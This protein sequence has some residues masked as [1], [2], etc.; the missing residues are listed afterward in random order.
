MKP[1]RM[2]QG[3]AAALMR[4][5]VDTDQIIPARFLK[6]TTKDGLGRHLFSDWRY[7]ADGSPDPEFVLNKNPEATALVV[8]DNFG[9]GSS[10]EHAPWALLDYGIRVLIGSGFADIFRSNALR[11]G[12]VAINLAIEERDRLAALCPDEISVN[13]FDQYVRF[14]DGKSTTFQLEPFARH[15]LLHG[16]NSLDFLISHSKAIDFYEEVHS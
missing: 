11:N 8:G 9:C 7:H 14:G 1:I 6:V 12:L 2:F 10:R 5:D 15:C 4:S 13:V 16:M 3:M